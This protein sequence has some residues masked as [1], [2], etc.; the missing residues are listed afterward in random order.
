VNF[1][2]GVSFDTDQIF[3]KMEKKLPRLLYLG[4]VPV[5]SSCHGSALIY[6]LLQNYPVEK[7]RIIEGKLRNSLPERRLTAV[8]YHFIKMG[9][10]RPLYT[11]FTRWAHLAYS[12]VAPWKANAVEQVLGNFQPE[13]VLTVTH[14]FLWLTAARYAQKHDLPLHLICHDDW[15]RLAPVPPAFRSWLEQEFEKVYHQAAL[16]LC[17]SPYMAEEYERRYGAKGTVL[18]PSRAANTPVFDSNNRAE[19]SN[20]RPFTVAYAGSLAT[21]D[22]VRQLAILS[23]LLFALGGRL[24][25]F[26]PFDEKLLQNAGMNLSNAVAGGLVPSDDLVRRLHGEADVLF[27]P[28]SFIATELEAMAL[29]FPSKLTDYT[30]AAL[31]LLIWGPETSSAVKWAASEPGVAAVVKNPDSSDMAA[32]LK[33]L[34]ERKEW[35][36]ELA[37]TAV[38]VGN[39]YFSPTVA[40]EVFLSN[41][42]RIT[43]AN[44]HA[45]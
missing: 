8:S 26:G 6:R 16:R 27:L 11:R 34:M 7:L 25:L 13:A 41:L 22:Y 19:V 36:N 33:K 42:N 44:S 5:E 18:Y 38:A 15:P 35:R 20:N 40:N 21:G 29:N 37:A 31:P 30:A 43:S 28:M 4:D 45:C 2:S 23:H 32:M 39:K 14:D 1:N 17:V 10:A 3:K 9:W 12:Y 24:L